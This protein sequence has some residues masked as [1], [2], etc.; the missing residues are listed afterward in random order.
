MARA[1]DRPSAPVARSHGIM[2]VA[3]GRMTAAVGNRRRL[4]DALAKCLRERK[5]R[6]P[7]SSVL[8]NSQAGKPDGLVAQ[9]TYRPC[10][11][12]AGAR[13]APSRRVRVKRCGKSAPRGW[14]QTWHAKPHTEQDQIGRRLRAAR[15]KSPGRLLDPASNAGA[16]GMVISPPPAQGRGEGGQN[17]AY[18]LAATLFIASTGPLSRHRTRLLPSSI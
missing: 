1:C 2:S 17:S 14:R 5:V 7:Q 4:G 8:G 12:S 10:S 6:T 11:R 9:K 18:R 15:P 13:S 3:V 16:R